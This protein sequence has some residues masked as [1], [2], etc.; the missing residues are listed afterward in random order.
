MNSRGNGEGSHRECIARFFE[1]READL[2]AGMN[3]VFYMCS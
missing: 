3:D 1:D 2:K